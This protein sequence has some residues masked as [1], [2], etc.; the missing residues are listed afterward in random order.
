MAINPGRAPAE[1]CGAGQVLATISPIDQRPARAVGVATG[2]DSARSYRSPSTSEALSSPLNPRVG[3]AHTLEDRHLSGIPTRT[4]LRLASQDSRLCALL[5]G[6]RHVLSEGPL[7]A[8]PRGG[9]EDGWPVAHG[10]AITKIRCG[11]DHPP[12]LGHRSASRD[13][14][15]GGEKGRGDRGIRSASPLFASMTT[16]TRAPRHVPWPCFTGVSPG[17]T[18]R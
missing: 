1:Q 18:S 15:P 14:W 10:G 9:I 17:W 2:W 8:V 16:T 12:L 3:L 4:G 6:D 11:D 5:P 13:R 7:G